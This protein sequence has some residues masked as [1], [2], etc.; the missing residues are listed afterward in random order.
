MAAASSFHRW[1]MEKGDT[2]DLKCL[3][4]EE[5]ASLEIF[6]L[7]GEFSPSTGEKGGG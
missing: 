4:S 3:N 5:K 6:N 2:H 7:S 1:K